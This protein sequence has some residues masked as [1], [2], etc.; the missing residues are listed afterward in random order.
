LDSKGA[1]TA[2]G[3]VGMLQLCAKLDYPPKMQFLKLDAKTTVR[4]RT[5]EDE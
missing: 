3:S 2:A 5:A 1:L 4:D